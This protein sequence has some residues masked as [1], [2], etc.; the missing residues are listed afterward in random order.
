M[1]R[2]GQI[3]S[4]PRRPIRKSRTG[5]PDG[6]NAIFTGDESRLADYVQ[7]DV[8]EMWVED[9]GSYSYDTQAGGSTT[10]PMFHVDKLVRKGS[11]S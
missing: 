11:C 2:R 6:D 3:R 10:V 8:V 5:I 9:R 1:P 7:D 4:A